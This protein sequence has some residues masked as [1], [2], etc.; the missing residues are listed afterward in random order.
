MKFDSLTTGEK[1]AIA[2]AILAAIGTFLPWMT[3]SVFGS[4]IN[5]Q[6]IDGD[7]VYV[8]ALAVVAIGII[9]IRDWGR[10]DSIGVAACGLLMTLVSGMYV[11]SPA[12]GLSGEGAEF[13]RQLLNPGMGLYVSA[14][15]SLGTLVGGAMGISSDEQAPTPTI[16]RR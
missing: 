8:L 10:I 1:V 11:V 5:V 3:A 13:A 4:T 9:A 16:D 2:G 14:L 12:T 15:G 7:G 6:G